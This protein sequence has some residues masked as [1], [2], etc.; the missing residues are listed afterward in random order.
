MGTMGR[1]VEN[2]VEHTNICRLLCFCYYT[3][4]LGPS[5]QNVLKSDMSLR[6]FSEKLSAQQTLLIYF[7]EFF[8]LLFFISIS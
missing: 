6:K 7:D 4:S 1:F 5:L 8:V 3:R 2:Y